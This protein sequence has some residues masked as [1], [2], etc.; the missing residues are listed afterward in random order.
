M[1]ESVSKQT[2]LRRSI[3]RFLENFRKIGKNNLTAAKIRSRIAALK[4]LWVSYQEGHDQLTKTIPTA[5]Q[6]A[7]DYFKEDYFSFTEEVYETT[8]DAM[9]ECLEEFEPVVSPNQ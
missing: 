9:V 1:T 4:E 8:L 3:E 6:P 2:R 5:T 7:L